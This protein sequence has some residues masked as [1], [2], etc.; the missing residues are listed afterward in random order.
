[1]VTFMFHIFFDSLASELKKIL[2]IIIIIIIIIIISLRVTISYDFVVNPFHSSM[3]S[4]N[5]AVLVDL[6]VNV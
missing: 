2:N 3:F 5:F 1:M 6:L 4:S